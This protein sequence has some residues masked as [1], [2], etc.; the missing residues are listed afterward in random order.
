M[1]WVNAL[2]DSMAVDRCMAK[3]WVHAQSKVA[4]SQRLSLSAGGAAGSFI[5]AL[6]RVGWK[7]PSYKSVM[8]R[9]GTIID[10]GNV[11]PR[12]VQQFLADAFPILAATS[13]DIVQRLC[14]GVTGQGG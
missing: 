4:K 14:G 1:A 2:W 9:D 13:S 11:A 6:S 12:T 8:T 10:L 5:V 3:A 7:S